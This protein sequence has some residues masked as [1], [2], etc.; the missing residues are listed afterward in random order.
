MPEEITDK[1]NVGNI[2]S[3]NL[4]EIEDRDALLQTARQIQQALNDKSQA[5]W[6]GRQLVPAELD[7]PGEPAGHINSPRAFN[8]RVI[9]FNCKTQEFAVAELDRLNEP[10]YLFARLPS[11]RVKTLYIRVERITPKEA[12]TTPRYRISEQRDQVLA[13]VKRHDIPMQ[14]LD[15]RTKLRVMTGQIKWI[16]VFNMS[17]QFSM[18]S[19]DRGTTNETVGSSCLGS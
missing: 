6:P 19:D 8:P 4:D 14:N 13:M 11:R 1:I 18:E 17:R 12:L 10:K 15:L 16:F 3:I 2:G 9:V 7:Y 5:F